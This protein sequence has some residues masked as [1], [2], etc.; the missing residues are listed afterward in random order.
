MPYF[1]KNASLVFSFTVVSVNTGTAAN[2]LKQKSSKIIFN[3]IIFSIK[4]NDSF[5]NSLKITGAASK[6]IAA[7]GVKFILL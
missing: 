2:K 7:S 5:Y 1:C 3:N 6:F 4:Y